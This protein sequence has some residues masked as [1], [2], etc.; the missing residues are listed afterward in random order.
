MF[1]IL[2]LIIL[3]ALNII[4][5]LIAVA[6]VR[7]IAILKSLGATSGSIMKIFMIEGVI[8]G[9][10]GTFFGTVLGLVTALNL[11]QIVS[12][13]ERSFHFKVLPPSVYY[14][15]KFPSKVDPV[16]VATIVVISISISFLATLY[17]VAGLGLT[18]SASGTNKAWQ[19]ET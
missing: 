11:E 5:T 8:I 9:L 1:I 4:S 2:T 19:S 17:P 16:V 12:F 13:I 6:M 10:V 15:D 7:D 18:P 14:I 3:A